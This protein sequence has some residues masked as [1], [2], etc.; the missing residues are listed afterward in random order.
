MKLWYHMVTG[1]R[2]SVF[3]HTSNLWLTV[4]LEKEYTGLAF[5]ILCNIAMIVF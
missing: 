1:V 4:H 5:K 3:A 2:N